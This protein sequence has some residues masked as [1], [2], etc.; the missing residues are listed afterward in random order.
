VGTRPLFRQRYFNLGDYYVVA[1]RLDN[2][3]LKDRQNFP[4]FKVRIEADIDGWP[5][6]T[7]IFYLPFQKAVR[8]C[9][10][11]ITE[12]F[13]LVKPVETFDGKNFEPIPIVLENRT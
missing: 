8:I 7:M 6:E 11:G 10:N 2:T 12:D 1:F 5:N 13:P 3:I 4:V 9:N